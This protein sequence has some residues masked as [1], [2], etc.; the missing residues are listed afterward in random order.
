MQRTNALCSNPIISADAKEFA[1]IV[2]NII[3]LL[4]LV[5]EFGRDDFW[6]FVF[7]S[8]FAPQRLGGRLLKLAVEE[9]PVKWMDR[10][11]AT[12]R[13]KGRASEMDRKTKCH[14]NEN[15]TEMNII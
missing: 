12:E 11:S 3:I 5:P 1:V 9:S 14:K 2:K 10:P 13:E 7:Q 15:G 6:L 8:S 4:D